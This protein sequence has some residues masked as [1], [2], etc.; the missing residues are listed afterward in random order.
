MRRFGA[1]ILSLGLLVGMASGPL[2]APA[3]A[4]SLKICGEVSVY[5]KATVLGTGLL[6]INGVPFVILAGVNLPASVAVGADVCL[7]LATSLAGLI[8]GAAV[9]ANVHTHIK[10]CGVV[11]A[12]TAATA[13]AIR[14]A[15]W[16]SRS[17]RCC[18]SSRTAPRRTA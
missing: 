1:L 14:T 4:G 16:C 12:Y 17:R 13:S 3:R 11:T 2:A 18:C 10:V 7:D 8:T 5:V 9:T 6:T 15:S